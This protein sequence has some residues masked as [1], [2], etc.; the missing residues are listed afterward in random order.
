MSERPNTIFIF[1]PKDMEDAIFKKELSYHGLKDE[2][3]IKKRKIVTRFDV[4]R[5]GTGWKVDVLGHWV[6][7]NLK[8]QEEP[9]AKK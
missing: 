4:T 5:S 7:N 1:I 6:D 2:A 8:Y 9:P 3:E